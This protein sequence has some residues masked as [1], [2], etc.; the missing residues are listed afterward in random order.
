M[1]VTI[2]EYCLRLAHFSRRSSRS[3]ITI[4]N[5]FW[6]LPF[7]MRVKF[8][9][10]KYWSQFS[11]FHGKY[12]PSVTNTIARRL[13]LSNKKAAAVLYFS[14]VTHSKTIP[15][16]H[17]SRE[18]SGW[19]D[20]RIF[21]Q[22]LHSLQTHQHIHFAMDKKGRK[23]FSDVENVHNALNTIK[24][25]I[26]WL[27]ATNTCE[28]LPALHKKQRTENKSGFPYHHSTT[29]HQIYPSYLAFKYRGFMWTEF[30]QDVGV[31]VSMG[32]RSESWNT[33]NPLNL[34]WG[35]GHGHGC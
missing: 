19:E 23:C 26:I 17:S 35:H 28:A 30:L 3:F 13:C 21:N 4:K 27:D 15:E 6:G 18:A 8:I 11:I 16:K 2:S 32:I 5:I 10:T 29:Q 22:K 33:A 24:C 31:D 20:R 7:T 12:F 25:D 34:H 14:L 9:S 1:C